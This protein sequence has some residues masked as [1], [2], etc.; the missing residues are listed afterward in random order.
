M[1]KQEERRQYV[2]I[3]KNY[4]VELQPLEFPLAAQKKIRVESADISSGGLRLSCDEK[5]GEGQT[6]QVRVYISGLNKHHPGF[7]KVFE[8]DAGQYLQAVSEVSWV[9]EKVAFE[10]YEMGLKF[11]DVYEDDWQALKTMLDRMQ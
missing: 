6:V 5:F 11:V 9:R 7:F 3:P 2:R 1:Q 8:S 10:L 4:R